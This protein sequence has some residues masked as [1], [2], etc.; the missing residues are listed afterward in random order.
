MNIERKAGILMHPISLPSEYGIGTL[1]VKCREFIDFLSEAN[2]KLWQIFPLGP[3]G[4][5]D[6]PYQCF[7]A[8]AGNPYLIDLENLVSLGL[9][10]YEDILPMKTNDA[11]IDYGKLYSIKIPILIKAYDNMNLLEKEFG[12][13]KKAN[14]EEWLE[15]YAMFMALKTYF[16]GASWDTWEEDIKLRKERALNKYSKKLEKE[17]DIQKFIQF[18]FFKQWAEIK[19]YANDKGIEVIGDIPIFVSFDSADAWSNPEIFLFDKDRKPVGVAGVPPDYFSATGQLWG[20]PLYNW[21]QLKKQDYNWWK[22]RIAANLAICDIIRIDHFRGFRAYWQ[23]PYG[24]TTAINGKWMKGPGIDLFNSIEKEFPNLKIIAED[25]GN[26]EKEDIELVN[27]TG[28]P[29][30]KILQ[31]AFDNDP[32]NIYLPHNYENSNCV[33]YTGTHD[34]DTTQGYINSLSEGEKGLIRDYLDTSDNEGLCWHLIRLAHR[35]VAKY[36]IIPIQDYLCYGSDTRINVPGVGV[37]NWQFKLREGV[38]THE[39]ANAIA[40]ITKI[41]GR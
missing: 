28:Y 25:L 39:L 37:G 27:A 24:E 15:N 35:S 3:T 31:F 8:F 26:L 40:H 10:T 36:S 4:F 19:K 7:S 1:G 20:N 38:L 21:E 14:D 13:F 18:L 9:L 34:N 41:Y 22:K 16:N 33:V 2:Q 30:M 29:G 12:E 11:V 17:I 23:V 6:S 5:G 32:K